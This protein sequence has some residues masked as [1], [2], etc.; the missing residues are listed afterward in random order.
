MTTPSPETGDPAGRAA[1][2]AGASGT[3][4]G[5]PDGALSTPS[6]P[7]SPAAATTATTPSTPREAP[8]RA[9][10]FSALGWGGLLLWQL[11]LSREVVRGLGE[12]AWGVWAAFATFRGYLLFL[13]GGLGQGI[14]RDAALEPREGKPARLRMRAAW[15]IGA[16]VAGIGVVLTLV[17]GPFAP[18]F[19]GMT[20]VAPDDV[21]AVAFL[22]GADAALALIAGPL[23]AILRGHRMFGAL[24]ATSVAQAVL[25]VALLALLLPAYGIVGAAAAAVAAR[26][27]VATGAFVWMRGRHLLPGGRGE[28]P[29]TAAVPDVL[30]FVLPIW[31]TVAAAQIAMRT[32]V[33]IV[34]R[35][36]GTTQAGHY[37]LGQQIPVAAASLLFTVMS[38]AF[39][40]FVAEGEERQRATAGRVTFMAC[41][42]AGL[43]FGFLALRADDILTAWIGRPPAPLSV[44]VARL[45][46]A[47][48][49]CNA[50]VHVLGTIAL[51]RGRHGVLV[52][53]AITGAVANFVLSIALAAA[54]HEN[55][56]AWATFGVMAAADLVVVP[57]LLLR[58]LELPVG[59]VVRGA[60]G[61]WGIGLAGAA[62]VSFGVGAAGL[63]PVAAVLVGG[64]AITVIAG[65]V[66]DV[67]VRGRSTLLSLLRGRSSS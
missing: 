23:P 66:L 25:G 46:C 38:F 7:T 31:L 29:A 61:G 58:R 4:T 22:L 27:V 42:L 24:A 54:G 52:P 50:A 47:A 30:R 15:R 44:E 62:A 55:G 11:L 67:A 60:L 59:S 20:S 48:W 3:P 16:I 6:I 49:G 28:G 45:Y 32:D 63:S 18:A 39:P 10:V 35:A 51:A 12:S 56:P 36:F 64:V 40:R 17:L 43:G 37:D 19:V 26:L 2:P 57:W 21:R 34:T 8:V 1:L 9:A 65:G 14:V 53:A 5:P 13:D 41:L 33:P